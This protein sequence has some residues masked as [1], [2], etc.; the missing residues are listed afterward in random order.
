MNIKTITNSITAVDRNTSTTETKKTV[1]SE[2][3]SADRDPNGQ[4]ERPKEGKQFLNDEELAQAIEKLKNFPGV[5]DNHL[6]V[7]L[8]VKEIARFVLITDSLGKV[9]RRIPE[10]ELWPLIQEKENNK[11]HLLDTAG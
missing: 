1:K 2:D 4:R 6:E 11:G 9:I 3:T 5:K 7:K 10:A 8:V